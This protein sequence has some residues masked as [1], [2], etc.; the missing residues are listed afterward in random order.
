MMGQLNSWTADT[1]DI[2]RVILKIFY[3]SIHQEVPQYLTSNSLHVWMVCVKRLMD[4][5][6]SPDL[7]SFLV[8]WDDIH[9]REGHTEWRIKALCTSIAW[10]Y[11]QITQTG[12]PLFRERLA[13]ASSGVGQRIHPEVRTRHV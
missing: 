10:K 9:K 11:S 1:P 8:S 4:R 13:G 7:V 12:L 2:V 5:S 3:N 6:P